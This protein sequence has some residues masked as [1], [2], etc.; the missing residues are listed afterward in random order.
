MQRSQNNS[1]DAAHRRLGFSPIEIAI[2]VAIVAVLIALSRP[3]YQRLRVSAEQNAVLN[4]L[5]QLNSA[6]EN[7]FLETGLTSVQSAELIGTNST[8]YIRQLQRV[9]D[10]SYSPVITK[11]EPITAAGIAGQRT[12][13][14]SN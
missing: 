5:H 13:T 12:I 10:E 6:S 7:Y 2:V 11:G 9:A 1:G 14:F 3:A 8:Q 4:N